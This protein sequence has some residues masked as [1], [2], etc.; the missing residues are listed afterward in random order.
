MQTHFRQPFERD[1]HRLSH[2]GTSIL[3]CELINTHLTNRDCYRSN[4]YTKY[5]A[6]AD[7]PS[8]SDA[9]GPRVTVPPKPAKR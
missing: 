4:F 3:G 2:R 8:R 7:L 5:V 1:L 6:Q 9:H